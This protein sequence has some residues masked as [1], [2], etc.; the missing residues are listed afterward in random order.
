MNRLITDYKTNESIMANIPII[1][2]MCQ[3]FESNFS[4]KTQLK[5]SMIPCRYMYY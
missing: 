1:T 3:Y 5:S 2:A 4:V